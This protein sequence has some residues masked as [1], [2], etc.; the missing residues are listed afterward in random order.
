[1][2]FINKILLQAKGAHKKIVLPESMDERI[3]KATATLLEQDL[4]HIVLI[5]NNQELNQKASELGVDI[6]KAEIFDPLHSN[7]TQQLVNAF[8]EKRKHKGVDIDQARK[9]LTTKHVYYGAL[10]VEEGIADGMVAGA[11]CPTA[12]TLRGL[13]HCIGLQEGA[14]LVSSFFIMISKN[15]NF[16]RDGILLFADCAVNPEPTSEQLANIAIQTA[17]SYQ[18]LFN[19]EAKVALLSFSTHGSAK[20]PLVDKVIDA[21]NICAQKAAHLKIDGDLQLDAAILPDVAKR[22][23]KES[24]VAGQANCLVFPDLQSGNI[25]YKLTERFAQVQAVGPFLQGAKKPV[26]DLSRG[27]SISDIVNVVALTSLQ[28]QDS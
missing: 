8:Y 20:H 5:G 12:E 15:K 4:A 2:D 16:G 9:L 25:G 23:A 6:G 11:Q 28:V 7:T 19:E 27:C 10:L 26:N 1:M 17:G 13:F 24:E 22:K 3:L 18:K 21:K 14:S